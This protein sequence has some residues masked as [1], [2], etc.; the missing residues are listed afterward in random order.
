MLIS[1]LLSMAY[2]FSHSKAVFTASKKYMKKI[3]FLCNLFSCS[4][5]LYVKGVNEI[6]KIL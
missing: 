6:N 1:D 2:F 3:L 5:V 4:A